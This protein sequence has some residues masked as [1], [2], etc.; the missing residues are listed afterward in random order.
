MDTASTEVLA[1]SFAQ[2]FRD[3]RVRTTAG[4]RCVRRQWTRAWR[5]VPAGLL[6]Q[7]AELLLKDGMPR[8]I[9]YEL[10]HH[11]RPA[12]APLTAASLRRLAVGLSSWAEVDPYALYLLGPAWREGR[13]TDAELLRWTRSKDRF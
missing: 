10:L 5:D 7:A 8:W 13:I 9:V 6:L 2:A 11:H 1:S 12:M 4:L 3:A